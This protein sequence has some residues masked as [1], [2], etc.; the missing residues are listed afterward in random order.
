M[1]NG[2]QLPFP[3]SIK[4]H[5]I[6]LSN[7]DDE[8]VQTPG[9]IQAHGM[10]LAVRIDDL[11]VT[12]VSD[13]CERWTA[14]RVDQVLGSALSRVVGSASAERI[15]ELV[16]TE[17]LDQNP[18]YALTSSLPGPPADAAVMDMTIHTADGVLL[19]EL[20]PSGRTLPAVGQDGDYF[21]TVRKTIGRLK[22]TRSLAEFCEVVAR[23]ARSITGLDRAMVYHFHA[24]DSGEVMADARRDDLP[25]WQGLRYPASDI[26]RPAREIFKKI[27][28]R[29]LPDAQGELC[30]MVPLLNPDTQRPLQM[31]HCALRGASVMYTEYLQNMGVAAT[32]TMPILRDGELWGLIACHHYTAKALAYPLRSAAE[33][34]AQIASLEIAQAEL[35]EHLQYRIDL[36]AVHLSVLAR[37]AGDGQLSIMNTGSPNLLDG[38]HADGI[39][40]FQEAR[41]HTAGVVPDASHLNPLAAW[42]RRRIDEAPDASQTFATDALGALHPPAAE[43]AEVASGVLATAVSRHP[44]SP[45]ILWFR[46]EQLQTYNWAGNP[47]EKPTA[48]G[49]LGPRLTPRRSFD[50]WQELVRGRSTP[51]RRVEVEAA[52]R[53]RRM[54]MDLVV[55]RADQLAV[56]NAELASSN[57][58]LDAF[59]YVA[60]HDLKEPLRG[61]NKY[62]HRLLEDTKAGRIQDPERVEWLLRMTVRMDTLLNALLHF[63]RVG[64]LSLDCAD[65]DLGPVLVEA[66]DMLGAR[67]AESRVEV[68]VPRPLPMAHCDRIRV[69][70]VFAN[71]ISN[72]TK[73]NDKPHP[74]VEIGCIGAQDEALALQR[75]ASTPAGARGDTLFYVRDN[76]IGIETRHKDR[77]FAIFK[78]LH[79]ADAFGG[80]SGAGLTIA[81]K[82]VQQHGGLIWFDS[83]VGEGTTF[84]FTLPDA[85]SSREAAHVA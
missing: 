12:Q 3:Y 48:V 2:M 47:G 9:C 59:A 64:R 76:G 62:A 22:S 36:D 60:G 46:G 27:G 63:S 75:P 10:L 55:V 61:I 29:P 45:L 8:P 73:Y 57:A 4:R 54:V 56:A 32:L 17:A 26:P 65:I 52:Q 41:W 16:R 51:W 20:E 68:R 67:L 30:E 69:R 74:W 49:P 14:L 84:Y 78:R 19:V 58:E 21:S 25:S 33:F 34:L 50:L 11:I 72:A 24:D 77:I 28:V 79:S 40:I 5:G 15:G 1:T 83:Q 85:G 80:G 44:D 6:S 35:R 23:E 81:R 43:L 70:E 7:C 13:N 82:M 31:T 42:L 37:A 66:M 39:A 38:I 53:L 71:L 18:C